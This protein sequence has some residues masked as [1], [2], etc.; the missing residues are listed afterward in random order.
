[1]RRRGVRDRIPC[2]YLERE[3]DEVL[4]Y[5]WN[6]RGRRAVAVQ[7]SDTSTSAVFFF[8]PSAEESKAL[9]VD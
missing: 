2:E 6:K 5:S 8:I 7:L 3:G 1:M 9:P 4:L